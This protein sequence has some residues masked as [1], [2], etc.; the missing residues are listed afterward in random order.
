M[1][2][3]KIRQSPDRVLDVRRA[4]LQLDAVLRKNCE[5]D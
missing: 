2:H 5:F 3:V 1:A 4:L